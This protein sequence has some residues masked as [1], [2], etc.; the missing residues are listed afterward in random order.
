M[1]SN[2]TK[3]LRR[4]FFPLKTREYKQIF[5]D[6]N[7]SD[8]DKNCY[9]IRLP[10]L[11]T[12]ENHY[13][14]LIIVTCLITTHR[15]IQNSNGGPKLPPGDKVTPYYGSRFSLNKKKLM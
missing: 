6:S 15:S 14:T 8:N 2:Q 12:I 1:T 7:T 13:N 5:F 11:Y 9:H 4:G 10:V 3:V